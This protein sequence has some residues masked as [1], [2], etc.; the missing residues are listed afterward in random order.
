MLWTI[1]VK[2]AVLKNALLC[3]GVM[4][5]MLLHLA[6]EHFVRVLKAKLTKQKHHTRAG[7]S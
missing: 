2:S 5:R 4:K 6:L 3:G 1:K 7:R